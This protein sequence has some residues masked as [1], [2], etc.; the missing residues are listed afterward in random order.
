MKL[1]PQPAGEP[2]FARY[3]V[4]LDGQTADVLAARVSAVPFNCAWPGCQ[5]PLDQTE[6][7]G[8][9]CC[10]SDGPVDVCVTVHAP[11]AAA[12]VRPL[13]RGIRP[14]RQ[15]DTL[16]FTLPGPG[17]YTLEPDDF[18]QALHLFI[19]PPQPPAPPDALY[20]GPGVH[21]IGLVELHSGQTVVLDAGAVVY[22]GFVA[23]DAE[24]I[25]ITGA[26]VLDGS[27]EVRTDDTRL[28][29]V[30]DTWSG[31]VEAGEEPSAAE[32]PDWF[33][34]TGRLR[35]YNARHRVLN[36]CIRL[37]GCR[38]CRIGPITCRDAASFT[39]LPAACEDVVIDGVKT[40]G[41]WRY[42]SDG[43]DIFNSTRCTIRNCF[44]RNF[45]DCVVI[46][47]IC[48]FGQLPNRDI[49]VENC[50]IWCDWGRALEIGAETN[51]SEYADITF[52]DCDVIHGSW[53][54]LDIQHHNTAEI[55]DILFENIRCEYTAAQL[56]FKM[57]DSLTQRYEEAAPLYAQ[58]VLL[59]AY[60]FDMGLFGPGHGGEHIH[61][62]RFADI[63]VL[64]DEGLPM[65]PCQFEGLGENNLVRDVVL[66]GLRLNGRPLST[67]AEVNLQCN[68]YTQNIQVRPEK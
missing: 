23:Y 17:Q 38:H 2:R 4:L 61:H 59:G 31:Y 57:Q 27:R 15:G 26:G 11:F 20:Y 34:D 18:H 47:G 48:G 13:A 29:P 6:P 8:F 41:M 54:Q 9:V 37:Y 19:D 62:L 46:K 56:P 7:A 33:L 63:Q 50:V 44:L 52:R 10:E 39:I 5:R 22:G 3:T 45:D 21:E 49:L 67:P 35:T 53:I 36:G 28:I 40:I 14:Q 55:H 42:N 51:A 1:T 30:L 65:P 25:T 16:R 32:A 12:V 68:A 58:P 66:Q 64:A 24:N 60:F 43:I